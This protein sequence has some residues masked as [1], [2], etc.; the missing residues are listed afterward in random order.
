[1]V[2]IPGGQVPALVYDR[3]V[4]MSVDYLLPL[5]IPS[6][7]TICYDIGTRK[8]AVQKPKSQKAKKLAVAY[9]RTISTITRLAGKRQLST[10]LYN[11][12]I[13]I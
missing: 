2:Y 9:D 10:V 11:T 3:F 13:G 4:R 8:K 7:P 12:Y 1:M 5:V 6:R